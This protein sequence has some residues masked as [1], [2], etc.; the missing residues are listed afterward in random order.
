MNMRWVTATMVAA[1]GLAQSAHAQDAR[2]W[3][4]RGGFHSIEPKSHNHPLVG[5]E[6]TIGLTFSV[7]YMLAPH[8][9]AELLGELPFLHEIT[10]AGAGVVGETELLTPTLSVQYHFNPDG[11]IRPYVGAGINY[12]RFSG[13]RTWG[14]LQGQ[15]LV[16]DSSF[17]PTAQFGLD[18]DAIPGWSITVDARWFE[19]DSNTTLGGVDLG[20]VE[21]DPFAFGLSLGRRF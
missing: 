1:L 9:G 5:V 11:R 3:I 10:L 12:T 19:I 4:V 7:T 14:A 18:I 16:L 6:D 15:K 20:T 8:W 13:E 17:G 21:I 2:D